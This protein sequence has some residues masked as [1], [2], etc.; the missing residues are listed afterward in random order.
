MNILFNL[1]AETNNFTG[2]FGF[3][4]NSGDYFYGDVSGS[5]ISTRFEGFVS[6]ISVGEETLQTDQAVIQGKYFG[7][8]E[9]KSVGG[10]IEV[11][12]ANKSISASFKADKVGGN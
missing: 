7:T 9:I 3:A 5:A 10:N 1:G 11:D 8:N 6:K 2:N 12:S 4:T